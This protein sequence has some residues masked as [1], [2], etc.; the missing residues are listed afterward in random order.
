MNT[1]NLNVH[2]LEKTRPDIL[3]WIPQLWEL[4]LGNYRIIKTFKRLVKKL[5]KQIDGNDV[6]DFNRLCFLIYGLSRSGKTALVKYLVRCITCE[7]LDPTTLN[8]C[9]ICPA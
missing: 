5:R 4:F 6:V 3:R 9:G 1:E 2:T 8:A 7:K